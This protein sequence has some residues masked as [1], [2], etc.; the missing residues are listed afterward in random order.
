MAKKRAQN[1]ALRPW[2]EE[3]YEIERDL[4]AVMRADAV[5]ADPERMKKVRALAKEK[6]EENKRKKEEAQKG[7][8][9]AAS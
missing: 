5:K 4:E 6:L 9:L 2:S 3:N 1:S 7:I 8:E